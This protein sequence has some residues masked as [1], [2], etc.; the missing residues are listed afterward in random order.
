MVQ[1]HIQGRGCGAGEMLGIL[2]NYL[3]NA[4]PIYL[5]N[6]ELMH[7]HPT[8]RSRHNHSQSRFTN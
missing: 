2:S 5:H 6:H 8:N 7:K 3:H 4:S 1:G